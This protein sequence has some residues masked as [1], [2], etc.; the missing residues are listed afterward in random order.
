MLIYYME[1]AIIEGE[2]WGSGLWFN[3]IEFLFIK[4]GNIGCNMRRYII[5]VYISVKYCCCF[6]VLK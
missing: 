3:F 2:K 5:F 4:V 1:D 6:R